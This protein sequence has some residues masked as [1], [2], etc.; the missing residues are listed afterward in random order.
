MSLND[1][2]SV[3]S[4]RQVRKRVGRGIGSGLG[5]TAGRGS[6]GEGA[7]TGG[8]NRG[9]LFEGGQFPF[10]MRLPKRGFS[11]HGHRVVY[12]TV[13][14]ARALARVSGK[15]LT[16]EALVKAGLANPGEAIKLV[17]KA[18]V[19]GKYSVT[20]NRVSAAV[21]S[22]IEA[23]GGSVVESDRA[24]AAEAKPAKP[25]AKS[26]DSKS[27]DKKPAGKK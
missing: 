14:L 26:N 24:A 2:T 20:V 7:R 19:K 8:K 25:Q 3:D 15:D 18:E 16:L 17:G 10:W 23:A 1:I 13:D 27:D 22:A 4:G 21:R 6:K 12:Q 11:N 5:K 9:P